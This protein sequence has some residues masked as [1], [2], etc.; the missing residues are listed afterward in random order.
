MSDA[1]LEDLRRGS[2]R[3]S[4]NCLAKVIEQSLSSSTTFSTSF[5]WRLPRGLYPFARTRGKLSY[6]TADEGLERKLVEGPMKVLDDLKVCKQRAIL[7]LQPHL[8]A[9]PTIMQLTG[10]KWWDRKKESYARCVELAFKSL[11]GRRTSVYT[12]VEHDIALTYVGEKL[13]V[14][15]RGKLDV[16]CFVSLDVAYERVPLAVILEFTMHENADDV[17]DRVVAYSSSVYS[18]VGYHVVPA[19]V[20][21]EDYEEDLVEDVLIVKNEDEHGISRR[22]LRRLKHLEELLTSPRELKRPKDELCSQCDVD[23]RKLC[24]LY[25]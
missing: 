10:K 21:I 23:L 13:D 18:D 6:S 17:V 15:L 19:I 22:L 4:L 25:R 20:V 14:V 16:L 5:S 7:R 8:Q 2:L 3:A 11:R 24:P 1:A 9:E 12:F